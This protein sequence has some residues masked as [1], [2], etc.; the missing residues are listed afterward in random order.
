M[1]D[2]VDPDPTLRVGVVTDADATTDGEFTELPAFSTPRVKV[3]LVSPVPVP[4]SIEFA[5]A[6][7]YKYPSMIFVFCAPNPYA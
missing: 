4:Q 1:R 2:T 5:V 3:Q 6:P 7:R